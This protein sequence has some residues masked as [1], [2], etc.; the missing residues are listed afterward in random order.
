MPFTRTPDGFGPR[1]IQLVSE[2][3]KLRK[4]AGVSGRLLATRTGLSQSKISRIEV[5]TITPTMPEVTAWAEAVGTTAETRDRLRS[6]TEAA[7][8]EV[9]SWQTLLTDRPHLQGDIG[10][11]ETAA[12]RIR[13][14]QPSIV[15]GLLQTV[16]YATSV[17]RMS[18]VPYTPEDLAAAVTGRMNRHAALY[19]NGERFEFLV[20]ELA[21]HWSPGPNE[22]L[23]TQ[24]ER[25]A[26]LITVES[27]PIGVIPHHATAVTAIPHGFVIYDGVAEDQTYVSIETVHANVLAVKPSD[28]TLYENQWSLLSRMAVFGDSARD[29]IAARASQLRG[30][31]P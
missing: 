16:E 19:G 14:F 15:P 21:L 22:V 23:M 3:R 20:T 1:H 7:H 25:I 9:H 24:L 27:I 12:R 28:V 18:A 26:A 2:L 6:L 8:A 11:R 30:G 31:R 17:F 5:G 10:Q 4:Q 29:L 13:T